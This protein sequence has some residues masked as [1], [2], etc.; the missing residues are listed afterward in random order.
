MVAAPF[1]IRYNHALA[2]RF[3]WQPAQAD[4]EAIVQENLEMAGN[5]SDHVIICGYG[6]RCT[7][8]R[9]RESA[10]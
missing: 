5:K 6:R 1:L 8:W 2:R 4:K 9:T 10:A 7:L 3:V